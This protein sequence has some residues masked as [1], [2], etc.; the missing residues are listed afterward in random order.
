MSSSLCVMTPAILIFCFKHQTLHGR[1]TTTTGRVRQVPRPGEAF[2]AL[3]LLELELPGRRL[4]F[5]QVQ[6]SYEQA[7]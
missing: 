3:S 6:G 4:V 2:T 1:H 5:I 7:R